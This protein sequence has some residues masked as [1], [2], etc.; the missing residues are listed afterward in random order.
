MN[1]LIKGLIIAEFILVLIVIVISHLV[2]TNDNFLFI[3]NINLYQLHDI[4]FEQSTELSQY[5]ADNIIRIR[6][7]VLNSNDIQSYITTSFDYAYAI[8][9]PFFL[10]LLI[11][12]ILLTNKSGT[13]H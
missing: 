3:N 9:G 1:R 5:I 6:E 10:I 4:G 13:R 2:I 12:I 7:M 11:E 8:L